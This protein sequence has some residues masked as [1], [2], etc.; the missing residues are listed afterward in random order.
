[1]NLY[2]SREEYLEAELQRAQQ[3]HR[4]LMAALDRVGFYVVRTQS[5]IEIHQKGKAT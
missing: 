2:T 3:L 1:M 4:E 5:G